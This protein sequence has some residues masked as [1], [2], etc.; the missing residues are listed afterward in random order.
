V[1][2]EPYHNPKILR[3]AKSAIAAGDDQ[4]AFQILQDGIATDPTDP[5]TRFELAKLFIKEGQ[6]QEALGLVNGLLSS[7]TK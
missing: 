5:W 7:Q 4:M 3:D 6:K 1:S 2:N